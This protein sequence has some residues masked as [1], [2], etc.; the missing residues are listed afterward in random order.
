MIAGRFT[1]GNGQICCAVKRVLVDKAIYQTVI[2]TLVA[3]A[4]TLKLGD[5]SDGT[6]DVGPLINEEAAKTVEAQIAKAKNEGATVLMGRA[7]HGA[8]I[9]PTILE[10]VKAEH[11]AFNEEIFGP[12]LPVIAF[13][14][15][16]EALVLADQSVYGLQAAIFTQDISRIMHAFQTLDVGTLVVNRS[17]AIRVENLPFGGMR[18]R[19]NG[20]EG[21]YET[22]IEMTEEK[23]MILADVFPALA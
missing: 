17:T 9:E 8:F 6:T 20:R 7:R 19:G 2:D 22:L 1:S 10:G 13:D 16:E 21:I 23:T 5:P 12:V 3:R 11:A 18:S 14:S 15:F 4:K